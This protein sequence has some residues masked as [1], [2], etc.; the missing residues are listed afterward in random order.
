MLALLAVL[1][2]QAPE[3]ARAESLLTAG[4]LAG[5]RTLAERLVAQNPRHAPSHV[6]LG[7]VWFAWPVIG[8]YPALA[9]FRTAAALAPDDPDPLYRQMEVGFYLGSDEGEVIARGA[10][11]RIFALDPDYRDAW[12]RFQQLF[13]NDAIARRADRAFARHGDHP[14]ALAR[15][16][17][18]AI[19]LREPWRADSLATLQ[20]ARGGSPVAGWV[21]R[22]E[23]AFLEGR[24]AVGAA[25]YD[26]A[27]VRAAGDSAGVLWA[28]AW[29]VAGPEET[30]GYAAT[31]A[32]ERA[33]FFRDFWGARD[34]NLLTAANERLGEH[35]RR[36][37]DARHQF[38]LLHPQRLV[39]RSAAARSLAWFD[40]RRRLAALGP[41]QD[42]AHERASRAGLDARG[43]MFVRHGPPD[44]RMPCALDPRYPAG[45]GACVSGLDVEGWLYRTP[46]GVLSVGFRRAEFFDPASAQQL[47]HVTTLLQTDG[48]ALPAPVPVRAWTAF[49]RSAAGMTDVYARAAAD[50]A[51][52][53]LWQPAG[54][55]AARAT[56]PGLLA[57]PVPPGLYRLGLDVDS[58]GVQGRLRDTLTVP[59]FAPGS[60]GVSSLVLAADTAP[61]ER[62]AVLATMPAGLTYT[63][64]AALGAYAEIYGLAGGGGVARYRA[65]YTFA[66]VRSFVGRLARGTDP[67]SFE[68]DRVAAAGDVVVERLVLEPGRVP[69]GRYR[70]TLAVTD[71]ERNVKSEAVALIV[72]LR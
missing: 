18:L 26:S 5:A 34:P 45:E 13:L 33:R 43:L 57:L 20:L 65:R 8:R 53:V 70:V 60:L 25:W 62:A 22:A 68:F 9:A 31:P 35:V 54:G 1:A 15:R 2:M 71:L 16:A 47:R 59:W 61:G 10:L 6:L 41:L 63:A 52:F 46:A 24:D 3:A 66:P 51:A 40:E 30:A 38:R 28:S 23:A 58:A 19:L 14:V 17:R 4:A 48:T 37:A 36:L 49:F 56:G 29:M 72:T 21:T 55:E 39:Y 7:R 32:R 42:T 44:L 50:A 27:L 11:L 12:S 69:P 67:V 64:G